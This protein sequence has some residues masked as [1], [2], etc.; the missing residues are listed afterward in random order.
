MLCA[1]GVTEDI[2]N[3]DS[4]G[5]LFC[6][7][8]LTGISSWGIECGGNSPGVFVRLKYFLPWIQKA[9][10]VLEEASS[11]TQDTTTTFNN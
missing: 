10:T 9:V 8:I 6:N 11:I 5:P 7:G 2:C 3:G 4:G 1:G